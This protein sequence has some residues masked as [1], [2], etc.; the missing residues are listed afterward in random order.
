MKLDKH[1]SDV[2]GLDT[3]SNELV[4]PADSARR[5]SINWRYN[6]QD[7]L[8]QAN[9]WQHK[10][11]NLPSTLSGLVEYK[12][13]DINSGLSRSQ[14]LAVC[15]NGNL[16]RKKAVYLKFTNISSYTS[17][18]FFYNAVSD[19][20]NFV[21]NTGLTPSVVLD[22]SISSTITDLRDN[23][24]GGSSAVCVVVDD[25]GVVVPAS[26]ELAYLS[27]TVINYALTVNEVIDGASS[28]YWELVVCPSAG[29]SFPVLPFPITQAHFGT[30]AYEGI[31][32]INQSNAV[33]IT[34]GGF[35]MKYDGYQVY[36]MGMPRMLYNINRV[37]GGTLLG[38]VNFS[39]FSIDGRRV[40]TPSASL[41]PGTYGYLM[42]FGFVDSSGATTLGA[43]EGGE[44]GALSQTLVSSN[45]GRIT[46]GYLEAGTNFPAWSA[47]VSG[48]QNLT[49]SGGT[50]TVSIGHNIKVGMLLRIPISNLVNARGGFSYIMSYVSAVAASS[51]TVDFGVAPDSGAPYQKVYPF[52]PTIAA[53]TGTITGGS[54]TITGAAGPGTISADLIGF[55]IISS[56][57]AFGTTITAVAGTT[58][59]LSN[60]ATGGGGAFDLQMVPY[61][62]ADGQTLQAG[63]A[64]NLYKNTITD[65]IN[66]EEW[67]PAIHFGAFIRI[68]RTGDDGTVFYKVFDIALSHLGTTLK[69]MDNIADAGL[70]IPFDAG[71]GGELP[72]AC[73]YLNVWQNQIIQAGRPVDPSVINSAYPSVSS[74]VTSVN[75]WGLVPNTYFGRVYSEAG[76]C[77]FQSFYWNDPTNPEGFPSSGL[78]ENLVESPF[79]DKLKGIGTNKDALFAFKEKTTAIVTGTLSIGD[80]TQ[81]LFEDD[82]GCA[83]H[84]TIQQ[85]DGAVVWLDPINGFYSCV[86]GRL[87]VPIGYSIVDEFKENPDNLDFS[88]S[89]AQNYEAENLYFCK[90]DTKLFV[91]DY[92]KTSNNSSRLSWYLW[93]GL[94]ANSFLADAN[95]N[96]LFGDS[97]KTWK[98]KTTNSKY[99]MS[100][101]ITAVNF[102]YLT[103]WQTYGA[104]T[105]DK[106]F[107]R[108]WLNSVQGDFTLGLNEYVNF[109]AASVADIS[110]SFP[111][112]ADSATVKQEIKSSYSKASG[113]SL[114]FSNSTVNSY[115]RLQ[116][117]E[118]ELDGE[119]SQAEPK[120]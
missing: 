89:F 53:C 32:Y 11:S 7:E 70:T 12:Y 6:F 65:I 5:G 106:H 1:Y 36:R 40:L 79:N 15:A 22:P 3:R 34:D 24:N 103:A 64:S 115:V 63:Y 101:H 46:P 117:F 88:K 31:S 50:I 42:Q 96:M 57:F 61:L 80:L 10:A 95:G 23:I 75:Q 92:A 56:L 113:Y 82:I 100:N 118:I 114:G 104:P 44:N 59:T 27:N 60:N 18:S 72:R 54:N 28:W 119:Y 110:V 71:T 20:W 30:S 68:F 85:V 9:G 48:F 29:D 52:Q 107:V 102:A 93:D 112:P 94:S 43:I 39:G 74:V 62:L 51:V 41:T 73:K 76:I 55:H 77:D 84:R 19:R 83:N 14:I 25:E 2:A 38:S 120:K 13:R 98:L 86:A 91:L 37:F 66:G 8:Q 69:V 78:Y 108:V 47:N 99:D 87:P 81:E 116:G 26:T 105:I 17:Y 97:V 58:L 35:P 4:Q 49:L 45:A 33:F 109:K 111:V 16:Y 67:S 90:V 21:L